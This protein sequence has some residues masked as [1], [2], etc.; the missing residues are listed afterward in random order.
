MPCP[1]RVDPLVGDRNNNQIITMQCSERYYYRVRQKHK[2]WCQSR[3]EKWIMKRIRFQLKQEIG[4]RAK[5][6]KTLSGR[7]ISKR[8]QNYV[9]IT[10]KISTCHGLKPQSLISLLLCVSIRGRLQLFSTSSFFQDT[11]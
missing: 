4:V 2:S 7:C 3:I 10:K 9:E 5:T 6:E 8:R 1:P 11:S